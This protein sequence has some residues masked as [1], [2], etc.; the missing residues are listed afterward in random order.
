MANKMVSKD[1]RTTYIENVSYKFGYNF[2]AFAL[3]ID[4]MYR[5]T[6]NRFFSCIFSYKLSSPL[7]YG[8]MWN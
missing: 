3:L 5:A 2:I 6:F 1:E 4:I 8:N 7:F